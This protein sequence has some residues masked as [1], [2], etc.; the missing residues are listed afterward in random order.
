MDKQTAT[1]IEQ[2]VSRFIIIVLSV[3][4]LS[5]MSN[6]D[7]RST[8]TDKVV[9]FRLYWFSDT[10]PKKTEN[11]KETDMRFIRL[12]YLIINNTADE[13]F[14]PIKRSIALEDDSMYC[15]EICAY[16]N[17]KPIY[18][19]L[20]TDTR[21]KGMLKPND[22]IRAELKIPEWVLDSAKVNKRIVLTELLRVIDVRYNRCLLDTVFSSSRIP[23]LYFTKNDTI[24]IHYRDT[25]TLL[26]GAILCP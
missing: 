12:H 17:N 15:S 4:F 3:L 9:E 14:L 26:N 25:T 8:N 20:S 18:S 11:A 16:I 13:C 19:W 7:N 10:Y 21:W 24:A 1:K 6:C 2:R 5:L 23:Q 22:S